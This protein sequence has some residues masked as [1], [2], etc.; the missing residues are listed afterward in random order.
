MLATRA[1]GKGASVKTVTYLKPLAPAGYVPPPLTPLG[2]K[3]LGLDP[4]L[5]LAS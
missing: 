1:S 4:W 2:R 3:L 5:G